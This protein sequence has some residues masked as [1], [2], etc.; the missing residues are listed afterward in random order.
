MSGALSGKTHNRIIH[1]DGRSSFSH[2]VTK[3]IIIIMIMIMIMIMMIMII[4]IIIIIIIIM[5]IIIK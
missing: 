3:I 5:I 1:V 2:L 4:I